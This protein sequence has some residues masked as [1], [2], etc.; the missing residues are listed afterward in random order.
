[1]IEFLEA[2]VIVPVW[3]VLLFGGVMFVVVHKTLR[4]I[5]ELQEDLI[6]TTCGKTELF[7]QRN[8]L[9]VIAE[10]ADMWQ[11]AEVRAGNDHLKSKLGQEKLWKEISKFEKEFYPLHDG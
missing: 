9:L 11:R 6:I 3:A 2:P 10:Q 1:M 8:G 7:K 4:W 5:K